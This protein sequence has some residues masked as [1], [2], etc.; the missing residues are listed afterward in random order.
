MLRYNNDNYKPT[1]KSIIMIK[2]M[3]ISLDRQDSSTSVISFEK[4][5]RDHQL[6]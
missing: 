4:V 6:L 1:K 5:L 3:D 2:L